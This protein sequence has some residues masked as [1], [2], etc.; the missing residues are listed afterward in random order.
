MLLI[1]IIEGE[2][3]NPEF[4]ALQKRVELSASIE[5]RALSPFEDKKSDL[6]TRAPLS[7]A[8]FFDLS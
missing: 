7:K 5:L 8:G 2:D 6:R 3:F 4:I 1:R